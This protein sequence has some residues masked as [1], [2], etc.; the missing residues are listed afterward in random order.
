[1]IHIII[2]IWQRSNSQRSAVCC[3]WSVSSCQCQ[4]RLGTVFYHLH[5]V[6]V[7]A[8]CCSCQHAEC[9]SWSHLQQSSGAAEV[10]AVPTLATPSAVWSWSSRSGCQHES[11]LDT[12]VVIQPVF[13][14]VIFA[15]V[16]GEIISTCYMWSLLLTCLLHH[17]QQQ[18]YLSAT[19]P[20]W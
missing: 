6:V 10:A 17:D 11:V 13:T 18:Q 7:P 5:T 15:S 3:L 19:V 12:L 20:E 4:W 1:M 8:A 9:H 14:V 16:G 2:A